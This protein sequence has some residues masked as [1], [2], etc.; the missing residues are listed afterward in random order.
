MNPPWLKENSNRSDH[1]L[2][3]SLHCQPGAKTTEIQGEYADRLKVRI[4]CAPV[5]GK[6]NEALI[7]WFSKT[8][9]LSGSSLELLSGE[10]SKQKRLKVKSLTAQQLLERLELS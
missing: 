7:K 3:L 1:W 6:A 5:D 10:S 9:S 4:A 2:E 8:L